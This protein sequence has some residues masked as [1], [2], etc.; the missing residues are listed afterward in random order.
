MVPSIA[1]SPDAT[2]LVSSENKTVKVWDSETGRVVLAF[3]GHASPVSRVV[4]SPD[5][6]C[7]ATEQSTT[8]GNRTTVVWDAETGRELFALDGAGGVCFS[9]NGSRLAGTM[10]NTT[11]VWDARSGRELFS[12]QDGEYVG[13]PGLAFSPDGNRLATSRN[14]GAGGGM[15]EMVLRDAQTGAELRSF[16]GHSANIRTIIFS[17]DGKR[18]I[19]GSG[20]PVG[21][22]NG[23]VKVW[24]AE[25]GY[26]LLTLKGGQVRGLA[27]SPNADQ[28]VV[29]NRGTVKIYDATPLPEKP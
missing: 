7:V 5:G 3:D 8:R 27:I 10:R 29:H 1:F 18:L 28:L 22:E 24:D 16:K 13:M 26:E 9:P 23:E 2:R 11:K 25:T 15:G 12:I 4:Y 20:N 6:K 21:I 14:L 17:P 19:S